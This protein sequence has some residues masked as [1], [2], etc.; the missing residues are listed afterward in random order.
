MYRGKEG[1]LRKKAEKSFSGNE[2][3]VIFKNFL[4]PKLA[5]CGL[6]LREIISP[7]ATWIFICIFLS[8][9]KK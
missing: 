5:A 4:I 6:I 7:Y 2:I 3:E 1:I 9:F 8:H